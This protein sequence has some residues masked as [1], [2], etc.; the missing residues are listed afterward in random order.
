MP[1][2]KGKQLEEREKLIQDALSHYNTSTKPSMRASADTFGIPWTTLRD[3]LNGAQNRRDAHRSMQLLSEHEETTIVRWCERMDDW[4]FPLRLSLVKEMAAYLVKKREI[5]RRLGKHWLARFL[6]R[7]PELASK[8]SARL[9]KQRA[10]LKQVI[11]LY[12]ILPKD[13]YNM[14]EKGF[15]MGIAAKVKVICRFGRKN[16]R[17]TYSCNRTWVTVIEAVSAA[18]VPVPPMIINQGVAHYI[19]WY[20]GVQKS[21]DAATFF[22]SPK[23]WTDSKLGMEWLIENFDKH[24]SNIYLFEARRRAY[25][26]KNILAAWDKVGIEPFNPRRVLDYIVAP[27]PSVT[28]PISGPTTPRTTRMARSTAKEA[29]GLQFLV[30]LLRKQG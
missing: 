4:G 18:G 11:T 13:K 15:M 19:G 25:T 22:Y 6:Q 3:R 29:F 16:P 17:L 30:E 12:D 20:V 2:Y 10:L 7:N 14:D 5:G 21:G 24:T 9:D 1:R 8:F 28:F 23:G 26:K 27:P